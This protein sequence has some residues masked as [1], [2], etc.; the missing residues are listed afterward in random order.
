MTTTNVQ[1]KSERNPNFMAGILPLDSSRISIDIIAGITLAALAIPEVMGYTK[2]AGMPVIT[3][4]YTIL[5]PT[6]LFALFGSSR[7][8]V[9]GADSATA[10]IMS[11]GL[12]G[13]ATTAS[14]EY[15]AYAGILALLAA[16][17]LILARLIKLGFLADFLSRTV[18]VGF[19]TGV[20]IQVAIGQIPGMLGI[21]GG[22]MGPV[23]DI[24]TDLKE[25]GQTNFYTL[26]VS[27]GVIVIIVGCRMINKKI[28]GAL[29]AV[30]GAIV[31]SY[32]VNLAQYGVAVLG[33]VPGGLP[34]IGLPTGATMNLTIL[35]QLAGIAF[36][37]F[38]VILAQSAATSRAYATRYSERFSENI[39]LV[40][41]GL[42]NIGAGLSGTFVVNGS[43]TKTQMLDSNGGRS[44]LATLTMS[45]LTLIVLLFLTKPLAFMPEAVLSSV[46]FL[47]G[48][49]L[50]D[51]KGM[52]KI[53]KE[54]PFE[55]WV[56]L[57]TALVVIF[58]GV[59]QGILLAIVLSILIHTRHGYK[60]KNAVLEVDPS[61]KQHMVP[62]INHAQAIPGLMV[63]RFHHSMYYANAELFSQE[64]LELVNSA[65]PPLAWFCIDA[66]AVD[67]VDFSAAA[68]LRELYNMLK[69]KGV[70]LV[71]AEVEED[72]RGELDRS[73]LTDLIGKDAF[74]ETLSDV[75]DAYRA[76]VSGNPA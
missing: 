50:V 23:Q 37:M 71:F 3:G 44:Q 11:A 8:L 16:G 34:K 52:R 30:I 67:D 14:P 68:T 74:F 55:F 63:Y 5:I 4:L 61:G 28:P 2:I 36:S 22:G 19:L 69:E 39:D 47:I 72:I 38:I 35:G 70:R 75:E 29:I 40:G 15:V 27:V 73:E 49:E 25:I 7:H 57:I 66:T 17:F 60:P 13:L 62:V 53:Y 56:A 26:A 46:V 48:I 54:R 6:A 21:P 31:L 18:L 12:V 45:V 51:A 20:G 41:L 65:Q 76:A 59:E 33:T 32:V 10:A 42:A 24:I 64:V 1:K 9:V 58:I 43:P